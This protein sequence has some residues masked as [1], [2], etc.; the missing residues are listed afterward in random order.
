MRESGVT[1]SPW[2]NMTVLAQQLKTN[3]LG[4]LTISTASGQGGL[5]GPP[6]CWLCHQPRKP[7][8]RPSCRICCR[9]ADP[10]RFGAFRCN[11]TTQTSEGACSGPIIGHLMGF[12]LQFCTF[13]N[14]RVK[15]HAHDNLP[16]SVF[17]MRRSASARLH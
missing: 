12:T 11:R 15:I 14:C 16:M 13:E 8:W 17:Q 4:T 3:A 6:L 5:F 9:T 1:Q 2:A 10:C 7:R